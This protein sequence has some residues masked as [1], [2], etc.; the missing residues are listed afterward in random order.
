MLPSSE[1]RGVVITEN[2]NNEKLEEE[3]ALVI[4]MR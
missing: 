2:F 1:T 4:N 3:M